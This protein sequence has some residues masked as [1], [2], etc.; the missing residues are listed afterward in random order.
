MSSEPPFGT[1]SSTPT[2]AGLSQMPS[3]GAS[4]A[5]RRFATDE[6]HETI[7]REIE[8]IFLARIQG[9]APKPNPAEELRQAE[10]KTPPHA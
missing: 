9:N 2:P 7:R 6:D 1:S 4:S 5:P 3:T 8:R 10:S